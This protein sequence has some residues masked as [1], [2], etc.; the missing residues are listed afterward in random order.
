MNN[1]K[2][3]PSGVYHNYNQSDLNYRK[4]FYFLLKKINAVEERLN[5]LQK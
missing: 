4:Q 2:K 3:D 5:K 1:Y